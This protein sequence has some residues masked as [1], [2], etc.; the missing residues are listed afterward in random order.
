MSWVIVL[1]VR[2]EGE[3]IDKGRRTDMTEAPF[4][5]TWG[6]EQWWVSSS[7]SSKSS[8]G[9]TSAWRVDTEEGEKN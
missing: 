2:P 4:F 5:D 8:L 7:I 1:T 9:L 6:W 3:E